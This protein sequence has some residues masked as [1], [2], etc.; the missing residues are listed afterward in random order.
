LYILKCPEKIYYLGE[1]LAIGTLV[2]PKKIE[3]LKNTKNTNTKI[4]KIWKT[5][6]SAIDENLANK[7]R[8]RKNRIYA[9]KV[10]T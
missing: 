1:N 3:N 6:K 10:K 7:H 5:R 9:K 2:I 8:G 4:Q